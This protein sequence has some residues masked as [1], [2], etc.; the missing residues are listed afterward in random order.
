[1]PGPEISS[2]QP[3]FF[4]LALISA[5]LTIGY[6]WGNRINRKRF[7]SVFDELIEMIKPEKQEHGNIG[8]TKEY[9]CNFS[10]KTGS[11]LERIDAKF[12][13][14]PRH[15]W[16]YLPIALLIDKYDGLLIALHFKEKLRDEAHIIEADYVKLRKA[17]IVNWDQMNKAFIKWGKHDYYI[18]YNSKKSYDRLKGLIDNVGDPGVVKHIALLPGQKKCF[19]FLIPQKGRVAK[20]LAPIYQWLLALD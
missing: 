15:L 13:F 12:T 18:Y 8:G 6:Y 1:M 16:P 20:D 17:K 4:I 7:E 14:L 2:Q 19:I 5:V 3:F 11:P 10:L 9:Y